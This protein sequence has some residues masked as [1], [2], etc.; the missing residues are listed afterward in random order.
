M[1]SSSAPAVPAP[2][3]VGRALR[4]WF[5]FQLKLLADAVRDFALS[6]VSTVLILIDVVMRHSEEESLFRRLM[7]AGQHSDQ[8]IN[9]FGHVEGTTA[10]IDTV[11][12]SAEQSLRNRAAQGHGQPRDPG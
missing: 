3:S 2:L 10:T 1:S 11:V 6:P 9:L 4:L 5:V 8:F 7:V 12:T